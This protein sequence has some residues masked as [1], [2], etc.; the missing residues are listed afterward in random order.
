LIGICPAWDIDAATGGCW[1][2]HDVPRLNLP[3]TPP[4]RSLDPSAS[5]N[6][7]ARQQDAIRAAQEADVRAAEKLGMTSFFAVTNRGTGARA[8][9]WF[10]AIAMSAFIAAFADNGAFAQT[11]GKIPQ[12][13]SSTFSWVRVRADGRNALF[14]DGWLDP[15]AGLRG[16]IKP[17]PDHPLRGNQDRGSG[18][19]TLA[20][21][22]YADPIL[23]PW[24]ASNSKSMPFAEN[25][26]IF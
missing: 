17:H 14:G 7:A 1:Q 3:C 23:K 19:V 22:N 18:Q 26:S 13:A 4:A 20:F 2:A 9:L 24:A 8:T 16:P 21:G 12:F 11:N 5:V 15:P 10:G 6:H 25:H